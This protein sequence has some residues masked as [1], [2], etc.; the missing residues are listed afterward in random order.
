MTGFYHWIIS[1]EPVH[2]CS[3]VELV[4]VQPE[5][6]ASSEVIGHIAETTTPT[7]SQHRIVAE[8]SCDGI[9]CVYDSHPSHCIPWHGTFLGSLCDFHWSSCHRSLIGT[10]HNN[11]DLTAAHQRQDSKTWNK[12]ITSCWEWS[13]CL[14]ILDDSSPVLPK[15]PQKAGLVL[16]RML[17]AQAMAIGGAAPHADIGSCWRN[18]RCLQHWLIHCTRRETCFQAAHGAAPPCHQAA[19]R[20]GCWVLPFPQV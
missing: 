17:A 19:R 2:P 13:Y 6:S 16:N 20:G 12:V 10:I 7:E 18:S 9:T 4:T 11:L 1:W 14:V 8:Q 3:S 15:L 5:A